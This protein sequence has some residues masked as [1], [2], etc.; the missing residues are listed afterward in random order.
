MDDLSWGKT[1]QVNTESTNVNKNE[2]P[3][4]GDDQ[5][6]NLEEDGDAKFIDRIDSSSK[7]IKTCS[8]S[9]SSANVS[10]EGNG[11]TVSSSSSSEAKKTKTKKKTCVQSEQV[12]PVVKTKKKKKKVAAK[13]P[14]P[15][16]SDGSLHSRTSNPSQTEVGE[17]SSARSSVE[18]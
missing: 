1:R 14:K 13:R 6:G 11:S 8:K 5:R 7:T 17:E 16:K 2:V 9:Y 3:L 4:A 18:K 15:T 12:I 10:P